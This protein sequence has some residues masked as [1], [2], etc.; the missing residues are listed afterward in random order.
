MDNREIYITRIKQD[1]IGPNGELDEVIDESP[2]ERYYC[3]IIYP[4][5]TE[6]S[7]EDDLGNDQV[8]SGGG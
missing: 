3:G 2:S 8:N 5:K 1:L 7:Q 6:L 4:K